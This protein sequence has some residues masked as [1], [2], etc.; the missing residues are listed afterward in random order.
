[1]TLFYIP[2]SK[3]S[4]WQRK[5]KESCRSNDALAL[6]YINIYHIV[7][8]YFLKQTSQFKLTLTIEVRLSTSILTNSI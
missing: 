2:Y 6:F 4:D 7:H 8:Y 5:L 1:M 3:L